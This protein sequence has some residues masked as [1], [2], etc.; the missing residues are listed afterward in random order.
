MQKFLYINEDPPEYEMPSG[1]K[2]KR[3]YV[4][5]VTATTFRGDGPE[6][7]IIYFLDQSDINTHQKTGQ[8]N[9][10]RSCGVP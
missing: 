6:K 5:E 7:L 4:Y 2:K 9:R 8:K 3:K 1:R 10:D